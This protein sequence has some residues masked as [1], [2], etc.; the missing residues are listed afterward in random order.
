MG[1]RKQKAVSGK[2][3]VIRGTAHERMKW[4][5][6]KWVSESQK[7]EAKLYYF[8]AFKK[9]KHQIKL[10]NNNNNNNNNGRLLSA[11]T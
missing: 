9:E 3:A 7:R 1:K 2:K 8:T 10:I 11:Q 4:K 5:V 6:K